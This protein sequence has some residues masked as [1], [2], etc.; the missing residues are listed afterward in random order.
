MGPAGSLWAEYKY[1][2][3]L[4]A[5]ESTKLRTSLTEQQ[6]RWLQRLV[7]YRHSAALI[8]G[9]GD[10]AIIMQSDWRVDLNRAYYE[11]HCIPRKEV[12]RW[13]EE[14]CLTGS[15]GEG[16]CTKF[17]EDLGTEEK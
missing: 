12:A 17:E 10:T 15:E 16:I 6:I 11:K 7:D 3:K 9:V 14:K 4:P 2:K 13:I 1:V 8:I 5:R